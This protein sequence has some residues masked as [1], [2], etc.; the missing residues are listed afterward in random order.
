MMKPML[1]SL[2][3]PATWVWSTNCTNSVPGAAN[4]SCSSYP[5]YVNPA[6]NETSMTVGTPNNTY[7]GTVSAGGYTSEATLVNVS[8]PCLGGLINNPVLCF[9]GL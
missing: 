5:V 1:I 9:N 3:S 4:S 7:I 8:T 2:L 6:F